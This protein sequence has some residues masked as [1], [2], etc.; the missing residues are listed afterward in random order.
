MRAIWIV[1]T[2]QNT[3][4]DGKTAQLSFD[5]LNCCMAWIG[6]IEEIASNHQQ[7]VAALSSQLDDLV[8]CGLD[9]VAVIIARLPRNLNEPSRWISAV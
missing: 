7:I 6:R 2:G 8:K 9:L 1:I 3:Y 5:M 4:R